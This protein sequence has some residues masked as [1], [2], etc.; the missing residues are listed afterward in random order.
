MIL[1]KLQKC[2]IKF[3]EIFAHKRL[4]MIMKIEMLDKFPECFKFGFEPHSWTLF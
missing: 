4:Y 1:T 3:G 2:V